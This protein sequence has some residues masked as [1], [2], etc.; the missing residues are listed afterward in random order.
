MAASGPVTP[1]SFRRRIGQSHESR[2]RT[3][4]PYNR[5]DRPLEWARRIDIPRR[6]GEN[7]G[8]LGAR[9][10]GPTSMVTWDGK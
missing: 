2:E 1:L 4:I 9:R 6:L 10:P 8:G 3:R 5:S 7:G